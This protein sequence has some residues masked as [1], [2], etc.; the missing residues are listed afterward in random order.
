MRMLS[1]HAPAGAPTGSDVLVDTGPGGAEYLAPSACP[2][3]AVPNLAALPQRSELDMA[4]KRTG[5]YKE[6]FGVNGLLQLLDLL[7]RVLN[8]FCHVQ[9]FGPHGLCSFLGSHAMGFLRQEY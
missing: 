2:W 5:C 1:S 9:H 6:E 4:E 8:P 3:E 7:L